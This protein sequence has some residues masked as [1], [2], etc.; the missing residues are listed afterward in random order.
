M[1]TTLETVSY[2]PTRPATAPSTGGWLSDLLGRVV[3]AYRV[4][5][6]RRALMGLG[7][8]TLK[9]IG[10]SRADVYREA[11]RSFWDLPDHR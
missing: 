8:P 6:E 1:S 7:D 2:C 3:L 9:D 5:G 4:F 11:T 10:L